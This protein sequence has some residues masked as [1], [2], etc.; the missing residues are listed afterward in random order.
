MEKDLGTKS[1]AS[2][3]YKNSRVSLSHELRNSPIPDNE[4]TGNLGLYIERMHL[5]RIFLMHELYKQ[6]VNIPGNIMEFG[7][8][9]GQNMAL[10]GIFRGIYEPYN[11]S[12]KVI[13]FDTF[14]GFPSLSEEDLPSNLQSKITAV[15]DYNVVDGWEEKL[16]NILSVQESLS[17]LPH[18]KKW[19]LIKG[20][21]TE[22]FPKYLDNHPELIIALAYFDFD[23]YFPTKSCLEKLIP[24]LTK[25]SIVVFDEL[26]CPEFPGETIAIQEVI[27]TRNIALRRDSNNPYVSWFIWE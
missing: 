2:N 17:P 24:R 15:G 3:E 18:I 20:D 7:V 27:G 25:G 6:V 10:F 1:S 9:W 11:Y 14:S 4:L 5:S 12:R 13:G 8:R 19:E 16:E 26:N 22:T 21:A 23:I